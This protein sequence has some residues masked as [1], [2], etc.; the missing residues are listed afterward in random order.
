[1]KS[2]EK[3]VKHTSNQAEFEKKQA[4][5]EEAEAHRVAAYSTSS[6]DA[7]SEILQSQLYAPLPEVLSD[8][9]SSQQPLDDASITQELRQITTALPELHESM[10]DMLRN[11][12]NYLLQLAEENELGL[13]LEEEDEDLVST[14]ENE[15]NNGAPATGMCHCLLNIKQ[16]LIP[17]R[18]W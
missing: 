7:L 3:T 11:E 10:E 8:V 15:L 5:H 17:H 9:A 2:H 12:V 16:E 13:W 18:R 4:A 1:M 6:V 14:V